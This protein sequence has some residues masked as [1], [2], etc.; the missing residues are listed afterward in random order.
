MKMDTGS[1]EQSNEGYEGGSLVLHETQAV[2]KK[3]SQNYLVQGILDTRL[4]SSWL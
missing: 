3:A 4:G 2:G 1:V